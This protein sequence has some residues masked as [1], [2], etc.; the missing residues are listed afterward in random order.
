MNIRIPKALLHGLFLAAGLVPAFCAEPAPANGPSTAPETVELPKFVVEDTR[1]IPA[2]ESWDYLAIPGYEILSSV[3][4]RETK[5]FVRELDEMQQVLA[6]LWPSV[7]KVPTGSPV[8]VLLCDKV[9]C[10]K[11]YMPKDKKDEASAHNQVLVYNSVGATLV[12][13]FAKTALTSSADDP[14]LA[15]IQNL[16]DS[17][18]M[19]DEP[20]PG[21]LENDPL[22]AVRDGYL[23][24]LLHKGGASA[25]TGMPAWLVEG[26]VQIIGAVDFTQKTVEIGRI[27]SE[28]GPRPKDFNVMLAT[29]KLLPM[30]QLFAGKPTAPEL[31]LTWESQCYAFVHMCL[32]GEKLKYRAPLVLFSERL[33]KEG[34]SEDLFRQ[35]FGEGYKDMQER[36]RAYTYYARHQYNRY[37]PKGAP[38]YVKREIPE[39]QPA[40]AAQVGRL[41]GEALCIIGEESSGLGFLIAPYQAGERD[42]ELLASIGLAETRVGR[43]E[44][45][46]KFLEA[47]AKGGCKRA[48]AYLNLA[49]LR[50]DQAMMGRNNQKLTRRELDLVLP[51]LRRGVEVQPNYPAQVEFLAQLLQGTAEPPTRADFD[52]LVQAAGPFS[53]RPAMVFQVASVAV[54]GGFT[55]EAG[56]WIAQGEKLTRD[57][58][59]LAHF[60]KLRAQLAKSGGSKP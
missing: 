46:R 11:D 19:T 58:R 3:S 40:T 52:F 31:E 6:H 21:E 23:R 34:L 4:R 37:D 50:L 35:C 47:A 42:P 5:L 10:F 33:N 24:L 15:M 38:V 44:R 26:M 48:E 39:P 59:G 17:V 8:T 55:Q 12:I 32:F 25:K 45:A 54:A 18:G 2:P 30:D 16:G 29:R 57:P 22:A 20:R 7:L 27:G 51:L 13:D 49:Q 28:S 56:E 14:R 43:T 9:D 41:R 1:L 53:A 36:L 60:Q